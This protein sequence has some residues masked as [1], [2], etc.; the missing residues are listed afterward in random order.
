MA[1]QIFLSLLIIIIVLLFVVV[2]NLL[3]K[4]L[5]IDSSKRQLI[6]S[7]VTLSIS[8][9]FYV[10]T[11]DSVLSSPPQLTSINNTIIWLSLSWFI[12]SLTTFFIWDGVLSDTQGHSTVPM[13]LRLL[14][15][16]IIWIVFISLMLKYVY[17]QSIVGLMAASG[18][19]AIIIGYASQGALADI[20]C[21]VTIALSH[22]IRR[23]DKVSIDDKIRGKVVEMGW[24]SVKLKG[25]REI[26]HI[27]PN[28]KLSKAIINN[29]SSANKQISLTCKVWVRSCHDP[30]L[31]SKL[32]NQSALDAILHRDPSSNEQAAIID[33]LINEY[34]VTYYSYTAL[35]IMPPGKYECKPEKNR[36]FLILANKLKKENLSFEETL[37]PL[38]KA[39]L[40]PEQID[41]KKQTENIVNILKQL[42]F[43]KG[44]ELDQFSEQL[45]SIKTEIFVANERIMIQGD[46]GNELFVIANGHCQLFETNSD[47]IFGMVRDLF[48]LP[49]QAHYDFFGLQGFLLQDKRRVTARAITTTRILRITRNHFN[50]II[51]ENKNIQINLA[52][53]LEDRIKENG[54]TLKS[55]QDEAKQYKVSIKTVLLNKIE[56]LFSIEK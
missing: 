11:T 51:N 9:L 28:T 2:F 24:R 14:Y 36:F 50:S 16:S 29:Y 6:S 33:S 48:G 53:I 49:D 13:I 38:H 27:I 25:W 12:T 1:R 47:G 18:V 44:L 55:I 30:E 41:H 3:L 34:G 52:T 15:N 7:A 39:P 31:I 20:F 32:L 45:S 40:D 54:R 26:I 42:P 43:L 8:L 21:G 23:G 10:L 4:I 22:N 56:Q 17:S 5:K 19:I 35:F 46:E 37:A